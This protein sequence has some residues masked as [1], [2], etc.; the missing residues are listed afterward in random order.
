M[1]QPQIT[2]PYLPRMNMPSQNGIK[3]V[4]GIEGAKAWQMAPNSNDVLM[5]SDNE[6]IFYIKLCDGAGMCTLRK[7]KYEEVTD[8]PTPN[9]NLTEYV[10]KDEL[11]GLIN[12]M[13]GGSNNE[14][15]VSTTKPT[16]I[17]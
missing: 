9:I 16:I 17:E 12:K 4:Q 2:N 7:F 15:S 14:Q 6:G 8:A 13:L 10:R 5:D 11:E 1:Y 3:W